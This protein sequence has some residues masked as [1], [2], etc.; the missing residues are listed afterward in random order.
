MELILYYNPIPLADASRL[1]GTLAALGVDLRVLS[2]S[3]LSQSVGFLAALK[4][5]ARRPAPAEPPKLTEPVM[6]LCGFTRER[7][8]VVLEALKA[9]GAPRALKAVLTQTNSAWT[10]A[11]LA[12]ELASEREAIARSAAKNQP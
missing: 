3:D 1:R 11:Q 5:H 7:L 10:V 2:P 9:S 8:D 12:G 6:V 4:G